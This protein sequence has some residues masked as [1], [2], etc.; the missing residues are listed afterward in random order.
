[1]NATSG[2]LP[3]PSL[4][5][6]E[7]A[8][9]IHN[10][11]TVGFSGFTPAGAAKAIP[12]AVAARARDEHNAGRPFQIGVITGASTGASLDGE[13]A[14]A[15]AI[16]FRTPY[17]SNQILRK[18]INEGKT[19]FFDMHLSG[20][21]TAILNGSLGKVDYA[22]V[23]ACDITANGEIVL[24]TSVGV[25]PTLCRV[26]DKIL[27]EL[28]AYH[29]ATLR[30]MH[31]I[32]EMPLPPNRREIP[33][34]KASDRAGIPV[35]K[36]DPKK[37]A[38]IVH[39]QL[40]DETGEFVPA[41]PVTDEIG[42]RVADFFASEIRAGRVPKEMLPVQSGVGNVANAVMAAMGNHPEIES[43]DMYSEVIQDSVIDLMDKGKIRFASGVSLSLA[44][45]TLK[46]VYGDLASYRDR[47]VLRPQD[48]TNNC[49][50]V[51]RLGILA[52]NTALEID[53]SGNV[54]STHVLGKDI[55]NGIGG[56]GDF[57]RNGYLSVFVAPSVAKGGKISAIVPLATHIDHNEHSVQVVVT[58]H[59][60]A[61]MRGKTPHERAK[62][63][64]ENCAHPDYRPMLRHYCNVLA[65][66]GHAPQS[67][68]DAFAMHRHFLETGDMRGVHW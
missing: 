5:P 39:T 19:R 3:F 9:L 36:V 50:I 1:M 17:Q 56:S 16:S 67:L 43:F 12:K 31:D 37:I 4:S 14:L 34:Y 15:D 7:A 66:D 51:R 32:Y 26:A 24:T 49:E 45:A 10:G 29:P 68:R 21:S 22:V 63:I 60:V 28:N 47:L 6:E 59:G 35:I 20:V 40:P 46:R 33:I 62:L 2:S 58:E 38:G 18:R 8:A 55:M 65:S 52:V 57:T 64:I 25:S 48:V 13:L 30:G 44:P 42:R 41:S 11:Q 61:D 54:N 23:E 27:V 53:L